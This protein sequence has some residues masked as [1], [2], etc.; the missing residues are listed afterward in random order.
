M[1][2]VGIVT[3]LDRA[4]QGLEKEDNNFIMKGV[5]GR[6]GSIDQVIILNYCINHFILY[7]VSLLNIHE[8]F[9]I[10]KLQVGGRF[11]HHLPKL[12]NQ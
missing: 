3:R 2:P 11:L 6:Y 1:C 5:W 7:G 8:F 10:D 9:N 4:Q 12:Y